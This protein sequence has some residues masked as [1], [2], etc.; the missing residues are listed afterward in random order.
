[1]VTHKNVSLTRHCSIWPVMVAIVLIVQP[2]AMDQIVNVAKRIT[3]CDRMAIVSTVIVIRPDHDHCSATAKEN[4]N[5][6]QVWPVKN[7]I[8]VRPITLHSANMVVNHAVVIHAVHWTMFH[9]AIQ[10]LVIVRAKKMSKENDAKSVDRDSLVWIWR[11]NSDA[12]HASAMATHQ[13]VKVLQAIRLFR[14]HQ[15]LTN[16]RRNGQPL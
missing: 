16:T 14:Q 7:V 12:H 8:V 2:I 9:R 11:I 1:M 5:V 13:S 4:A 15:T 6:N 10:K 3:T